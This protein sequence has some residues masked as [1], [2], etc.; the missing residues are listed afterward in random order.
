MTVQQGGMGECDVAAHQS[1][2]L[3]VVV[4]SN[5]S[6]AVHHK[7]TELGVLVGLTALGHLNTGVS[8]SALLAKD[9]TGELVQGVLHG[10]LTPVGHIL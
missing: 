10:G 6:Q 9:W 7:S 4:V 8:A 3:S 2:A 1:L 5:N